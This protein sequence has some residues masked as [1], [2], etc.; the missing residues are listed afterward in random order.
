[1]E[2]VKE[3][4]DAT[5]DWDTAFQEVSSLT[6]RCWMNWWLFCLFPFC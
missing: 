3:V 6:G 1:M 4:V 2:Q 5:G